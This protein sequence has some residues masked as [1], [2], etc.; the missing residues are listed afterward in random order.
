MSIFDFSVIVFVLQTK[1]RQTDCTAAPSMSF[2]RA[3]ARLVRFFAS[4][5]A[6]NS[7]G[8]C[9]LVGVTGRWMPE[10]NCN[11]E[12]F[13]ERT[14]YSIFGPLALCRGLRLSGRTPS[15]TKLLLLIGL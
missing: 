9:N 15:T 10:S 2:I 1:P 14:W 8:R 7:C 11:A 12:H 13:Q 4:D 5:L 3:L 6:A